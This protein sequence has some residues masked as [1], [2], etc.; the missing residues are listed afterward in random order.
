MM[1]TSILIPFPLKY[2]KEF[3]YKL[4]FIILRKYAYGIFIKRR[5]FFQQCIFYYYIIYNIVM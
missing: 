1:L 4:F 3:V 5:F 2:Y